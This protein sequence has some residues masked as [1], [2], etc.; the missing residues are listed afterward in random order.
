M[1]VRSKWETC[2]MKFLDADI[3]KPLALATSTVDTGH[4]VNAHQMITTEVTRSEKKKK[5]RV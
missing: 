5:L 3:R 4:H 2:D 1:G